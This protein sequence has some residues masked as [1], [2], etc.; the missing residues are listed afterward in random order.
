MG[1]SGQRDAPTALP[2]REGPWYPLCRKMGDASGL[3]WMC[4]E[5]L[6]IPGVP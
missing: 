3:L 5:N 1:V 2:P 6:I 4:A